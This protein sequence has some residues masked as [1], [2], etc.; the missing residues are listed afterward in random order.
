MGRAG[1]CRTGGRRASEVR[2]SRRPL[3]YRR[4]SRRKDRET[5]LPLKEPRQSRCR[6]AATPGAASSA[7]SVYP[8]TEARTGRGS[9]SADGSA[10]RADR[11]D[12]NQWRGSGLAKHNSERWITRLAR[13]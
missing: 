11:A 3:P 13:R 5:G 2:G 8:E 10:C 7:G 12:A 9:A 6:H 4:P 1:R